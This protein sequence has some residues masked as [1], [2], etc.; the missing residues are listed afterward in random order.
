MLLGTAFAD[1]N[2]ISPLDGLHTSLATTFWPEVFLHQIERECL[3][4]LFISSRRIKSSE[5]IGIEGRNND[6]LCKATGLLG[7]LEG[8][9]EK[10]GEGRNTDRGSTLP[11][12]GCG[13]H[14]GTFGDKKRYLSEQK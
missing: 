3:T 11:I 1:W 12:L 7:G 14:I 10:R 8:A 5:Q 4:L 9:L 6:K 13:Q 2:D